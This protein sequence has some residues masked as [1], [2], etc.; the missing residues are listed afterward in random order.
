MRFCTILSLACLA[1]TACN[2]IDVDRFPTLNAALE[3][4]TESPN[5]LGEL[6]LPVAP[7]DAGDQAWVKRVIPLL[8]GRQPSSI[9]EIHVLTEMAQQLGRDKVLRAM[10]KAPDYFTRWEFFFKDALDVARLGFS[11]NPGCYG[12]SLRPEITVDVAEHV[13]EHKPD[14]SPL[15]PSFTMRDLIHSALLLDDI[16]PIYLANLPANLYRHLDDMHVLAAIAQRRSRAQSFV[17][18]Y[19]NRRMTCLACHNSEQSVTGHPDPEYDRTWEIPGHYEKAIF[20]L[21]HTANIMQ[22]IRYFR[23]KGVRGG[24]YYTHDDA[25]DDLKRAERFK[26][27]RPWG[28]DESC[29]YLL[30]PDEVL[31]DDVLE[32]ESFFVEESGSS[33]SIWD[34]EA[35][36]R[37]GLE[38]LRK[39]GVNLNELDVDG[40]EAFA[41]LW[42]LNVADR[43]WQAAF[44]KR[45]TIA[46][47]FARNQLQRDTLQSMAQVFTE[48][49]YSLVELLVAITTHPYFNGAAPE[50]EAE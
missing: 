30:P 40:Q 8:W 11:S 2:H 45:L 7:R 38:K 42:T 41:F 36:M 34:L 27:I 26:S 25:G 15:S 3:A 14:G 13:L 50:S 20:G 1:V 32:W 33:A 10:A 47:F 22:L 43:V 29:G 18:H 46:L 37:A 5:P 19:L 12:R 6:L 23:R 9:N 21:S 31:E 35:H 4:Q 48:N 49:G 16:S 17:Y 39:D 28:W 44:G 24:Y